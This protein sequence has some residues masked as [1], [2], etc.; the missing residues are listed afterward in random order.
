LLPVISIF[1]G[2]ASNQTLFGIKMETTQ[3][4]KAIAPRVLGGNAE[5]AANAE[6]L[7]IAVVGFANG[8]LTPT[9]WKKTRENFF[10]IGKGVWAKTVE[11]KKPQGVDFDFLSRDEV[12]KLAVEWSLQEKRLLEATRED[13]RQML[14][15]ASNGTNALLSFVKSRNNQFKTGV[16]LVTGKPIAKFRNGKIEIDWCISSSAAG[17]FNLAGFAVASFVANAKTDRPPLRQCQLESCGKFFFI[18]KS[19]PGR[20]RERYCCAAHMAEAH[21]KNSALRVRQSRTRKRQAQLMKG[22]RRNPK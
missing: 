19:G 22:N 17:I 18:Q 10:K 7:M 3:D 8:D 15:C 2:D 13:V 5:S 21:V 14:K 6:L 1:N 9:H 20:V 11:T 16:G 12:D 4:L